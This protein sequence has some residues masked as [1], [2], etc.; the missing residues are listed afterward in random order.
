ME[1]A[2]ERYTEEFVTFGTRIDKSPIVAAGVECLRDILMEVRAISAQVRSSSGA[3]GNLL[4]VGG[5]APETSVSGSYLGRQSGWFIGGPG[6]DYYSDDY[7]FIFDVGGDDVYNLSYDPSDP[8]GVIII[9]L[10]G[11]D[12]YKAASD[13]ALGSGCL[14]AGILIDMPTSLAERTIHVWLSCGSQT[15]T[16]QRTSPPAPLS[17]ALQ[18]F[19]VVPNGLECFKLILCAHISPTLLDHTKWRSS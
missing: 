2:E 6:N 9:D 1:K 3:A 15:G 4:A 19:F 17:M 18:S 11:D 10:S 14:S 5:V 8:H 7:K 13:F 16:G 12:V